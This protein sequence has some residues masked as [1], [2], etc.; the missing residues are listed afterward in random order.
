LNFDLG[1]ENDLDRVKMNQHAKY[2]YI[3]D[4]LDTETAHTHKHTAD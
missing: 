2:I 4:H 3:K 1:Y